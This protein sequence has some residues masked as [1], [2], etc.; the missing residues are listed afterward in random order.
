ML[1]KVTRSLIVII[2]AAAFFACASANVTFVSQA[3]ADITTSN[4]VSN[5]LNS[6]LNITYAIT[7]SPAVNN[8]TVMLFYK[9]N[10]SSSDCWIK[11]NGSNAECNFQNQTY[12]SVNSSS[13]RFSFDDDDVYPATYNLAEEVMES[14]LH[15]STARNSN[16][17]F[18]Q[19]QLLNVSGA[20]NYSTLDIMANST[21][22]AGA[23]TFYYC[24][25]SYASGNPT[26]SAFCSLFGTVAGGTAYN[27]TNSA[28]SS[29]IVISLPIN[30]TA[31]TVGA[32][33]VTPTSY[34]L[35]RG[36]SGGGGWLFW[37]ISNQSR[38]GATKTSGN[39]GNTWTS[40]TYTVD[41]HLHQY[42]GSEAFR[43][44]AC[45]NDTL[46]NQNCSQQRTDLLNLAG[47]APSSPTVSSPAFGYYDAG[48]PINYTAAV[49]PNGYP[50]ISYNISLLNPDQS[51]NRTIVSNN[52]PSLGYAWDS[53]S[54]PEGSYIVKVAACDNQ[55]QCSFG[56]SGNF[57]VD[58]TSPA[59]QLAAPSETSGSS[60]NRRYVLANATASDAYLASL[61]INLYNSSGARMNTSTAAGTQLFANFSI[62]SD[63]TYFF[64]AT[65]TDLASNSNT[66][67]TRNVTIDTVAPL[68]AAGLPA[69]GAAYNVT[70]VAFNFSATDDRS[71]TLN[72]SMYLDGALSSSN[73][74]VDNNTLTGL[75]AT[76]VSSGVHSWQADCLDAAGNLAASA[77]RSFSV[78]TDAPV[79]ALASPA[80]G[81]YFQ[82][83]SATFSF[84]EADSVHAT[85]NCS[86]YLDG[87]YNATNATARNSTATSFT[88]NGI[89][90]ADHTWQVQCMDAAGNL[91]SEA[92]RAFFVDM[93]PPLVG[94]VSPSEA[95][96]SYVNRT[97]L[98]FN[99]TASD[100]HLANLTIY[101]Y[102]SQGAAVNSSTAGT[103]T[104]LADFSA[105]TA[106]RYYF[107]A[108]AWDLAGNENSTAT[109]NV[110]I[111]LAAPTV[112][113]NLP[114][115]NSAFS[116]TTV[117][118]NFT[119]ADDWS[120][121]AN[122]TLYVD[123]AYSS[124]NQATAN[125]TL[126]SLSA[127]GIGSGYHQWQV[128]CADGAG[129]T[130]ASA[131]RNFSVATDAPVVSLG[132]PSNG[133]YFSAQ[134]VT[135][136][137]T[138]AD[139][140][141][142][143]ANCSL[144][145]D[146]SANQ[147]NASAQNGTVTGFAVDGIP[148]AGHSWQVQCT[149]AAGNLGVSAT[150]SF[151][152]DLTDPVPTILYPAEGAVIAT[153]AQIPLN[154]TVA[155]SGSGVDL[156][157][158]SY[159][160]DGNATG[161]QVPGCANTTFDVQDS[162]GVGHTIE[163]FVQDLAGNSH[164]A[165]VDF[166]ISF[167]ARGQGATNRVVPSLSHSFNCSSGTLTVTASYFGLNIAGLGLNLTNIG[168]HE[169][170]TV[171]SDADGAAG[172]QV[173]QDG[174]YSV[175]SLASSQYLAGQAGTFG[176]ALCPEAQQGGVSAT[177][178]P[179]ATPAAGPTAI[180]A[181]AEASDAIQKAESAILGKTNIGADVTQA[182]G[183]LDAAKAALAA[184][185][186]ARAKA[187]AQSSMQLALSAESAQAAAGSNSTR[188]VVQPS[189]IRVAAAGPDWAPAVYAASL[190]AV[191]AGVYYFFL[192][193]A[194]PL[195]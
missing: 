148:E 116:N 88:V 103:G 22:A 145:L 9:T 186:Y 118:F 119:E 168:T 90:E 70:T 73:Q 140:V 7:G 101:L 4:L 66:T 23:A 71:A 114:A 62:A 180:P 164:A 94:F 192:R 33:N 181:K 72:C 65:A 107:N 32:V 26:T 159:Y 16:A 184:G 98:L 12:S 55:S 158:C 40:Q 147:T 176:L 31:G 61:T 60:A 105:G 30:S 37:H 177:A 157:S 139:S 175:S 38:V 81:A 172:F 39:T 137:F 122:C 8:T 14:T 91:G 63:G 183:R 56:L 89:A 25:S 185:D 76:G 189:G 20:K 171:Q 59:V 75:V 151:G 47:L 155:D 120:Q 152:I 92:A 96:G 104:L 106:G 150:R 126:T 102:G 67:A 36:A 78:A 112:T 178:T 80:D 34:I 167:P 193:P 28:F 68:V 54:A 21:A 153:N 188:N 97:S 42:D 87:A 166:A 82:S 10:S 6:S 146:G 135:F 100:A 24:N 19:I 49:S 46:G 52:S 83:Q 134:S 149:D 169:S 58:R 109:R 144:Y 64:N 18:V 170:R 133:T 143:A 187:L 108:T 43:Y 5:F 11:V 132:L 41:A 45:A 127:T 27:Q 79:V 74:S 179:T 84:T 2:C 117:T 86:L 182:E 195:P 57:T 69:D 13:Y 191:L 110:T 44:Y 190:A 154:F 111:D 15:T 161:V 53:T 130:G 29:H 3:P 113:A 1:R 85:A 48:I 138:E 35:M 124:G 123:G 93:T 160:L 128:M 194:R 174:T 125:S 17:Q 142:P 165:N 95:G 115:N 51:F 121:Q 99:A 77:A 141:H 129:N 136:S 162:V 131:A 173:S 50:I 163:L 156:S